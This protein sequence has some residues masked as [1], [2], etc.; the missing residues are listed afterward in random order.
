MYFSYIRFLS[1]QAFPLILIA[2]IVQIVYWVEIGQIFET[3]ES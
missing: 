1:L 3:G 2:M